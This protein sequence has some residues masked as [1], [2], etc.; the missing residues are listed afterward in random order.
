MSEPVPEL[1]RPDSSATLTGSFG[2][3]ELASGDVL[4]GRFRIVGVLGVGGMGVV[5]RAHDLSLGLDIAIKLLRPELAR[6]PEAFE[7]FK[8]ELLLARQVSSPHVVRIHDIAQHEGRWFISMDFIDGD[9]LERRLEQATK[10][11]IDQAIAW[12]RCLL[13]GLAAAH[14]RGVIHRDLKPANILLDRD[15]NAFIT[16]FGVARS[17]GA[18]G[19]TQ[20][21]IIVGTP[22]YLSPEQARGDRVDARSDLYA[23]GLIVYEMLS[24]RL[25]FS[26]GT[27]AETVMQRLVRS[28]PSLARSRPDLPHWLHAFVDRLLRLTP[29][30]RFASANDALQALEQR[31]VPRA[32]LNRRALLLGI[33]A[34]SAVLAAADGMRRLLEF[35]RSDSVAVTPVIETTP[36]F[37]VLPISAPPDDAELHALARVIEEHARSGLRNDPAIAVAPRERIIAAIARAAPGANDEMLLRRLADVSRASNDGQLIHGRVIRRPDGLSLQL[38]RFDPSSGADVPLGSD[39]VGDSAAALMDRYIAAP[40]TLLGAHPAN[41]ASPLQG[42][43]AVALGNALLALDAGHPDA[44]LAALNTKFDDPMNPLLTRARLDAQ[45]AAR[46]EQPAQATRDAVLALPAHDENAASVELR[47]RALR[48]NR[49]TQA[50][51]ALL[52]RA[53]IT[54]PHDPGLVLLDAEIQIAGGD[55]VGAQLL[56]Q[57]YVATDAQDVRAWFLLGRAAI[58]QGQAQ[59]AVEDYLV[60]ALVLATRSADTRGEADAHNAL[61]VGYERLG[62]LD[63]AIE[64][65]TRAAAMRAQLGDV[66]DHATSLRNLAIVQAVQGNRA[67]AEVNL[68]LARV[69]LEKL[70]DRASLADLH[71]D[72]GVVA[73]ERGDYVAALAAYREALALRQQLNLPSAVALSLNNVG[74]CYFQLGEIDNAAVYWQQALSQFEQINDRSGA[75]HVTQSIGLLEI[76]R[77]H[78]KAASERLR[79]SVSQAEDLQLPEEVAVGH[80]Y[81]AELA[82][83]EGHYAETLDE[84]T[85]ARGAFARRDDQRGL[86]EAD[87]MLARARLALGDAKAARRVLAEMSVAALNPEQQAMHALAEARLLEQ[88]GDQTPAITIALDRASQAATTAHSGALALELRIERARRAILTNDTRR[89]TALISELQKESARRGQAPLRLVT[90]ELQLAAAARRGARDSAAIDAYRE[91]ARLLKEVGSWHDASLLHELG[92]RAVDG[93]GE[94]VASARAA[95]QTA[96]DELLAAAPAPARSALEKEIMRQLREMS[97]DERLR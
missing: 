38:L 30:H 62:Q 74:F 48:G 68:Q 14:H 41:P 40:G 92:A 19:M 94:E 4:S 85:L 6:R 20:S 49:D 91:A 55:Q 97:G 47:A 64:Q 17:L 7:R 1:F 16:D 10:P 5:Y 36:H 84:A 90:L 53:R 78:F 70:G 77:G 18:T 56:L 71:N 13:G 82:L 65:Y 63:A 33:L 46:L 34:V 73:E 79:K 9:S 75:L 25:P 37:S 54:F 32:P 58:E 83:A 28:P 43:D 81:L 3:H 96:R 45:E 22:E 72:R 52:R 87:L 44:A 69:E 59:R 42:T 8:Q 11:T 67:D 76:A 21:G 60:H 93:A 15:E 12:T 27:P 23:I 51:A 57:G 29:A 35:P 61:G 2:S 88:E 31:R 89:A 50:A 86:A 66:R 24:G 26:V 80:V 95:A 39:L